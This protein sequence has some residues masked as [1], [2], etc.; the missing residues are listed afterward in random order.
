MQVH[1]L[2]LINKLTYLIINLI[3]IYSDIQ[4]CKYLCTG[5]YLLRIIQA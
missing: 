4:L 3:I 1:T 2:L 5:P